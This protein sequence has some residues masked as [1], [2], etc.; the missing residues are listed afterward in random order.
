MNIYAKIVRVVYVLT[1]PITSLILH[2]SQRVRVAVLCEDFILLQKT[3][4]G[5]QRWSL[6]GGGVEKHETPEY[7]ASRELKEEV[8]IQVPIKNLQFLTQARIP[9][10]KRYPATN[11]TF[12]H[13][14][15]N[16]KIKP[17]ITRPLEVLQAEWFSIDNLPSDRSE[18][19]TMALNLIDNK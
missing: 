6:P 10:G 8:G 9:V 13:V 17:Q 7:A 15:L 18:V 4:L 2:N 14:S 19:V 3:S 16:S 11:M 12:Y 5:S 1:K